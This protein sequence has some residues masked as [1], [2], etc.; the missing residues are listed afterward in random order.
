MALFKFD[1][2]KKES[3]SQKSLYAMILQ[4]FGIGLL[5]MK[6]IISSYGL[7]DTINDI[8]FVLVILVMWAALMLTFS[9]RHDRKEK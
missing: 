3:I 4:A 8:T 6:I 1:K 5:L 2:S 7:T 9:D